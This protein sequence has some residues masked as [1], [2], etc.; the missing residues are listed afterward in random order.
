MALYFRWRKME[1]TS[2]F[3]GIALILTLIAGTAYAVSFGFDVDQDGNVDDSAEVTLYESETVAID[4]YLVGWDKGTNIFGLDYYLRWD[5]HSLE[6]VSHS[7]DL[8]IWTDCK[9]NEEEGLFITQ[10]KESPGIEG[11]NILLDTVVLRCKTAPSNDW[12]RATLSPKGVIVDIEGGSY[13]DVDDANAI[14]HQIGCVSDE[15]C[16]DGLF[17]N[18]EEICEGGACK[19]GTDP[20][21][22]LKCNEDTNLCK[23]TSATTTIIKTSPDISMTSI[24]KTALP[25][26]PDSTES[27]TTITITTPITLNTSTIPESNTKTIESPAIKTK[28]SSKTTTAL[29]PPTTILFSSPYR[30]AISPSSVMLNSGGMVQFSIKTISD[31]N[32]VKGKYLWKIVPA[33]SIGSIIDENGLFTAGNNTS[34]SII[35]ETVLATDHLHESNYLTAT[36][37]INVKKQPLVGC[38]LLINL[39]SATILPG[40]TIRFF[41][42]N[43]GESCMEGSHKWKTNSKIGSK[44]SENGLYTAGNNASGNS[45]IDIIIVK[46]TTNRISTDAIVTVLSTEK[47][48][49][50]VP[51]STQKPQQESLSGRGIYSTVLFIIV[52]TSLFLVGIVLFRRLKR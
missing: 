12:I 44:I 21:P 45:A 28:L 30:V 36:V 22:G 2:I 8:S 51:D 19:P 24:F 46:D 38:E 27:I 37:T 6:L 25:P 5:T 26:T 50:V 40:D 4:I 9:Y 33:S 10:Y 31:E 29:I 7:C 14:V 39:T 32:E 42:K 52:L 15:D 34:G 41:A 1:K 35:K 20:C 23:S 3:C 48:A 43:F 47:V 18:G 17:C 11:P 16:D 13:K 49:Q